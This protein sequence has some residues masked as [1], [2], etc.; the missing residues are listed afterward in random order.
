MQGRALDLYKEGVIPHSSWTEAQF[1]ALASLVAMEGAEV[2][3]YDEYTN[4]HLH[5][6]WE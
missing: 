3:P 6:E 4:H 2:L 5:A 1:N